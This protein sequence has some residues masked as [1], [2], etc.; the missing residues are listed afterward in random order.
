MKDERLTEAFQDEEVQNALRKVFLWHTHNVD[1]LRVV[2]VNS[3]LNE[4][5]DILYKKY[6]ISF[7]QY[8]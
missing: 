6:Q 7:E 5:E 2:S 8:T 3:A 1:T 4:L